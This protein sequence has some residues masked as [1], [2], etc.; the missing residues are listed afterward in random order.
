SNAFKYTESG[1]VSISFGMEAATGNSGNI[2]LLINVADTGQGMTEEQVEQLFN[3][4][5]TRYNIE[6]NRTIEGSGLGMSI[7][8]QMIHMM[9]GSI[10]LVS[11]PNVGTKFT[12]RLPQTLS[13]SDTLG[14]QMVESL[15]NLEI[16]SRYVKSAPVIR[17]PMPYGRVLVVDDVESNLYVAKGLLKPYKLTVDTA[18]SGFEAVDIVGNGHAYDIIF[19]DY[20]M[21]GMD[22]IEAFRIIRG[23]GYNAPIIALTANTIAGQD[24]MFLQSGFNG[25]IAKPIDP[26]RLDA[27][28]TQFIRDKHSPSEHEKAVKVSPRT[29]V[30][31]SAEE[32]GGSLPVKLVESFLRDA[33]KAVSVLSAVMDSQKFSEDDIKDYVLYTHGLKS[34][35]FNVGQQDLSKESLA[36]E[37]AGRS[38][39]MDVIRVST[40][41]FLANLRAVM[42]ELAPP[43]RI[44]NSV[45]EDTQ[46]LHTQLAAIADACDTYQVNQARK[47][48]NQ[49]GE[50]Q[51]SASTSDLLSK[52]EIYLINADIEEAAELARSVC[53]AN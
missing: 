20:M 21:P 7:A 35:L 15:Q 43:E 26:A 36:L 45:D 52:L 9:N 27:I 10:D 8:Y 18:G 11:K 50:K 29:R 44:I 34:A 32:S 30:E 25:F 53:N 16:S 2:V 23:M 28:L 49:L 38:S 37:M 41:D 22:G 48:L 17:E 4:E 6:S 5:F 47:A 42:A 40:P 51:W 31:S 1:E 24:D 12:V 39:N 13:S 33:E 19:M 3:N 14:R 46:L